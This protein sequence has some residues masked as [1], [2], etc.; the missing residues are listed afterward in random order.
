MLWPG[1]RCDLCGDLLLFG[2]LTTTAGGVFCPAHQDLPQCHSCGAPFDGRGRLCA[3]CATSTVDTQDQLRA[4]IPKVRAGLRAMGI[5]L[6][7]PVHVQLVDGA[8]M[9]AE[10][11]GEPGRVSGLTRMRGHQVTDILVVAGLPEV[12]FG[13]TVAHEVMHAWLKQNRFPQC[14]PRVEEGLCQIVA[15]RWLRDHPGR[16]AEAL[17]TGI[18]RDPDPVY[19]AGFRMVKEAVRGHGMNAVL[20][21]VRA[22]GR[23][24]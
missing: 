2:A 23:L 21:A 8:R 18:E 22:T 17:R 4:L 10:S 19:G 15:H 12:G 20:T 7:Q 11:A 9:Q 3:G 5:V 14:D 13:A 24:P 6:P 16:P 1:R